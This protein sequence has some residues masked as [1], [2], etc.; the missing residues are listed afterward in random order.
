DRAAVAA[1]MQHGIPVAI[2][3]GRLYGATRPV[4]AELGLS[5]PHVCVDGAVVVAYPGD[6]EIYHAGIAGAAADAVRGALSRDGLAALA[7]VDDAVVLDAK[8]APFER[9]VRH[10][11]P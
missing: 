1:L 6:D 2:V 10:M 11:S 5:G 4:A 8:S 9:Q 3:T 7:I